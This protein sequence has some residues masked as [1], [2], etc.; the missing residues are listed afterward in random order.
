VRQAIG[1]ARLVATWRTRAHGD[2][3][4]IA[5]NEG[6]TDLVLY[7]MYVVNKGGDL[8]TPQPAPAGACF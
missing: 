1:P 4:H 7:L 3:V 8:R 2:V 5:R 6:T